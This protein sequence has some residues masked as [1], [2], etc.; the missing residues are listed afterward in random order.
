MRYLVSALAIVAIGLACSSSEAKSPKRG[1]SENQFQY[2]AQMEVLS[3]GVSWFY[4]WA[5]TP[6][7]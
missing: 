4:N 3:P 5:N 1:V 2:K 7:N 6:G